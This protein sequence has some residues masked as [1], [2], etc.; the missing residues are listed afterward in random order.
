MNIC[1]FHKELYIH[2][3]VCIHI[4]VYILTSQKWLLFFHLFFPIHID[5][6]LIQQ[7]TKLHKVENL[8]LRRS[9]FIC[10]SNKKVKVKLK[11]K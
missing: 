1:I 9:K 2:T 8:F 5:L 10:L 3:Y 11:G 4:H 7:N 6:S